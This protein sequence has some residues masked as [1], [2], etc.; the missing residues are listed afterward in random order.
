M[1]AAVRAEDGTYAYSVPLDQ[2]DVSNPS[3]LRTTRTGT[4]SGGCAAKIPSTTVPTVCS[5]RT[6]P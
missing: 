4:S 1:P 6:D 5:D 3:C 2:I